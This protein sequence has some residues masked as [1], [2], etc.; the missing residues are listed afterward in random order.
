M[1]ENIQDAES[2]IRDTDV[3]EEM[4]AYTK[5]NIDSTGLRVVVNVH[6]SVVPGGLGQTGTSGNTKILGIGLAVR[7]VDDVLAV[8]KLA[9]DRVLLRW[10]SEQR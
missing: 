5:N 4:M 3:A 1:T 2:T 6:R 8:L 10:L 7:Q 9:V